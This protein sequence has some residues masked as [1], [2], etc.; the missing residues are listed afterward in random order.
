MDRNLNPRPNAMFAMYHWPEDYAAQRGG[1]MD[2][3][4]A[5]HPADQKYCNDAVS[6]IVGTA[7]AWGVSVKEGEETSR[8]PAPRIVKR[9]K[10]RAK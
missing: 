7:I 2:F 5:L 3:F 9:R 10:P 6:A 8:K 1:V 4:D